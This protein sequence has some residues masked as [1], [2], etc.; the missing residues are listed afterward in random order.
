MFNT[1]Q[2]NWADV[3]IWLLGKKISGARAV[4]YK[5]S[6]EKEAIYGAGNQPMGIGLGNKS[7]EGEISLLQSEIEALTLSALA[8][9]GDDITDLAEMNIIINY[10]PKNGA[11]T[12]DI[13]LSVAFTEM[14]KGMSQ[15]DKFSEISLPFIALGIKKGV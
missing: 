11:L 8:A 5:V 3:E 4:K 14:E 12:V 2:Y 1:K 6:Q 10:A 15:N 13:L 7:Y 9:G